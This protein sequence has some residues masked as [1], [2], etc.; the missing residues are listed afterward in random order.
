MRIDFSKISSEQELCQT[1]NELTAEAALDAE[2]FAAF[3]KRRV[4]LY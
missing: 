1:F 4:E 2:E 3:E